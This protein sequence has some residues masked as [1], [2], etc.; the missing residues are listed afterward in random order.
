MPDNANRSP[1]VE[2][3][4]QEQ[5]RQRE[6][7]GKGELDKGLEDTFP[8]SDPLSVTSTSIPSGRTDTDKAERVRVNPDP[9]ALLGS[10]VAEAPTI[11]GDI[12]IMIRE[13]PLSAVGIVAA[14][15]YL[16]G[17]SR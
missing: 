6:R 12:R 3:L 9:T 2:S 4:K 7:I 1:A 5:A 15:A 17:A 8:A 13:R 11:L 16:L 14:V 10:D